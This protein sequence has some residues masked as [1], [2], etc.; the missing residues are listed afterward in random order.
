MI[1]ISK[2]NYR[3]TLGKLLRLPLKLIP[4][5]TVLPIMQG[6]LKGKKWV[7][8]SSINGCWLGTY[9]A[10]KQIMF[11][12]YIKPGLIVYDIGA[13]AGFYTL[14]TSVLTG[15]TGKVFAFEPVPK[16]CEY[17]KR[18]IKLNNLTNVTIIEKAVSD[19]SEKLKFSLSTNPSMG[20]LSDSGEIEVET[21]SLDQFVE[22][23]NPKPDLIKMDIEG[24]ELRALKGALKTLKGN[25]PV[26]FLATHNKEFHL[27]CIDLLKSIGYKLKPIDSIDLNE[28]SELI[29]E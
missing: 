23:G 20:H 4:E 29:A 7:K 26:I 8:G 21:I 15:N 10:D 1:N 27:G 25:K 16:N 24:A 13:N 5:Q 18:H 28:C 22:N 14:L 6:V 17:V 11:Q 3:S 12:N 2:L 9:E 19:K